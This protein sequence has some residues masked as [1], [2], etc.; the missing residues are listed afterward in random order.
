MQRRIYS[1]YKSYC[2]TY[3]VSYISFNETDPSEDLTYNQC[4]KGLHPNIANQNRLVCWFTGKLKI[5]LLL[6]TCQYSFSCR[7]SFFVIGKSNHVCRRRSPFGS[8]DKV[9]NQCVH[10]FALSIR[11]SSWAKEETGRDHQRPS[12]ETKGNIHQY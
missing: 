6:L 10:L 4:K 12:Q 11:N 1:Q 2:I 9:E 3:F 7:E 5:V 8:D